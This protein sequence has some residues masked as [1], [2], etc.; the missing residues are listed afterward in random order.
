MMLM[1]YMQ[2]SFLAW[3]QVHQHGARHVAA[4]RGLVEVDVDAL[5]LQV[6]V[7]VVGARG[8]DAM[9]IGDDLPKLRADLVAALAS[10]LHKELRYSVYL[11]DYTI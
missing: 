8:V 9:L 7:T 6:R 2:L 1:V 5:Q 10:P 3:L 4:P 11:S